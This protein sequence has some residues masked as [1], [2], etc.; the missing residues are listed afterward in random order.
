MK[1]IILTAIVILAC[2]VNAQT[3]PTG[4]DWK[5][6]SGRKSEEIGVVYHATNGSVQFN[7]S[8]GGDDPNPNQ[9]WTYERTDKNVGWK[10]S[11]GTFEFTS[12]YVW[13]DF[14]T[15]LDK[16]SGVPG[17]IVEYGYYN[18]DAEGHASDPVALYIKD[19]EGMKENSVIFQQ[20]DKIGVYLKIKENNGNTVTFTSSETDIANTSAASPNVD[21]NSRGKENQYFCLFDNREGHDGIGNFSHYE[22]FFGGLVA[23]DGS[24]GEFIDQVNKENDGKT[25]VTVN[26]QP[27]PGTLATLL[28]GG[29]CAGALRKRKK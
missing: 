15:Q 14:N 9:M 28:I 3:Y 5:S 1:K 26:G 13:T 16:R 25:N 12:K 23:S 4:N 18:I 21:T 2:A 29:L 20:G 17:T 7:Y 19:A 6:S 27:L 24:Y 10:Y 8:W 22:Y 11:G